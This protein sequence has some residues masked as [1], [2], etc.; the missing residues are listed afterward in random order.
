MNY[1]KL[2]QYDFDGANETFNTIA[3][4]K[5]ESEFKLNTLYPNPASAYVTVNF[6][7]EAAGIYFLNILDDE[8]KAIYSALIAGIEGE[9]QF[10]LAVYP[11]SNGNYFMKIRSPKN[12]YVTTK[13]VIQH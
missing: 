8:G 13:L 1:Y 9:N 2:V 4:N 6:Q 5:R 10:N 12:E 3:I 7:S 11:F